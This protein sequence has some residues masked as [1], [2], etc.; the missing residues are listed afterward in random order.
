[1]SQ[2]NVGIIAAGKAGS[3]IHLPI[4]HSHEKTDSISIFDPDKKQT[5][6]ISTKFNSVNTYTNLDNMLST[7]NPDIVSICSP[8]QF[9]LEHAKLA[10][11]HGCHVLL[12][13]PMVTST[14]EADELKKYNDESEQDVCVVHNKKYR[15]DFQT[16][17]QRVATGEIGEIVHFH[18]NWY[19]DFEYDRMLSDP[20]HWSHDLPGGRWGETLPHEIYIPYYF[21]GEMELVSV[22]PLSKEA[23]DTTNVNLHE[24]ILIT[25]EAANAFVT[26][27][28]STNT[29][30]KVRNYLISGSE[31][32]ININGSITNLTENKPKHQPDRFIAANKTYLGETKDFAQAVAGKIQR[33]IAGESD[34][35]GSHELLIDEFLNYVS[36]DGEIPVDWDEAYTTMRLASQIGD[37]MEK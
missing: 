20:D 32:I 31:G 4:Y 37:E 18:I 10:L 26:I 2:F 34:V 19:R 9:H 11:E 21:L 3:K 30:D 17:K 22:E 28:Y 36:G 25:L 27:R 14:E 33:E 24:D 6:K 8:P 1:M 16:V 15:N 5:T 29:P 13:K 35:K 23:S 7:E 12:E